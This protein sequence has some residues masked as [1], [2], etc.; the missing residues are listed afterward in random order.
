MKKVL[1]ML[2]MSMFAVQGFAQKE[3]TLKAGT[4][5]PLRATNTVAAADVDEG[6]KVSFSVSRDVNIDGVT[7]IPYGTLASGTVTLAKKSSWWG[8]RGRLSI[9]LTELVMPNGT[10]IPLQNG[11]LQI[12]GKNR[13]VLSVCL[14][15][16]VVWPACFICGS[17]AEM[18]AGYELQANVAS[19]TKLIV[20]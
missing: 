2:M 15:A 6:D 20:E 1:V 8:T 4:V 7:A 3:V 18:R 10:V 19:N 11:N 12:K 9:E 17:K 16:F 14:F 5:I 13:T